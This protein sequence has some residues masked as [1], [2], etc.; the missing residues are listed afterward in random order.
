MRNILRQFFNCE[1]DLDDERIPRDRDYRKTLE[2]ISKERAYFKEVLSPGDDKRLGELDDLRFHAA[3][4]D[5]YAHF[6]C[7]LRLGI[8]LMSEVYGREE[9]TED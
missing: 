7:G 3:M 6:T 8:Q 5:Y 2:K 4:M 9:Y 1:I